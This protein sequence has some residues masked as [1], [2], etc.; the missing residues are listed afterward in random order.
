MRKGDHGTIQGDN[1]GVKVKQIGIGF[2]GLVVAAW[3]TALIAR[4]MG[5]SLFVAPATRET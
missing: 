4:Q 5:A 3:L 1:G 2:G